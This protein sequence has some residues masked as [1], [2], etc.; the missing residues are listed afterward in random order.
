MP[1]RERDGSSSRQ[2]LP[3]DDLNRARRTAFLIARRRGASVQDAEDLAQEVMLR[4]WRHACR[5][6]V[7]NTSWI[8]KVLP[9][10]ALA[11]MR[12]RKPFAGLTMEPSIEVELESGPADEDLLAS[13]LE[14]LPRRQQNVLKLRFHNRWT[15]AEIAEVEGITPRAARHTCDRAIQTVRNWWAARANR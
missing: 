15:F 3:D 10:C 4:W 2:I 1:R 8:L 11:A 13:F 12:H 14:R 7:P 5:D 9:Q 6:A